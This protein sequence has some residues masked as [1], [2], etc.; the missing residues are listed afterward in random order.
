MSLTR[1][2]QLV[3]CNSEEEWMTDA[4]KVAFATSDM[5]RVNQ[6]F[7]AAKAF[8]VYALTR[9]KVCFLEA[10]EFDKLNTEGRPRGLE[11]TPIEDGDGA[12]LL[13]ATGRNEDKL[14]EKIA[15]LDGCIAA[16]S[17]AIGA[18]AINRLQAK[19]IQP[20]KVAAG[21]SISDLLASLQKEL[22]QDQVG[23]LTRALR[24]TLPDDPSRFER[25]ELDGWEE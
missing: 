9:D 15:A 7:G 2:L 10:V 23:W 20:V 21:T 6:H 4:L 12:P 11:S 24:R 17:Q 19:G 1:R 3:G 8:A 14:S 16:Y 22:R 5:Q 18:S 25:M 13:D